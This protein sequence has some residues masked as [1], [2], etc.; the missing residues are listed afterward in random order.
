MNKRYIYLLLVMVGAIAFV[1]SLF[2]PLLSIRE[3]YIFR[4]TLTIYSVMQALFASGEW[5]LFLAIFIFGLL[6]PLAKYA[7]LF[8]YGI[9]SNDYKPENKIIHLLEG[10]SKWAMLDVFIIA[11]LI[12]SIKLKS[13][14][15][16][17]THYGLYLFA[18]SIL[19][20]VVC[21][22]FYKHILHKA[23]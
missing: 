16:A 21:T 17:Q 3:F 14:A 15:S 10:V 23:K 8:V 13:T 12:A 11:I 19:I 22:Y 18:L 5:L 20:A 9:V 1:F 2:S 4:D 6:L 7:L